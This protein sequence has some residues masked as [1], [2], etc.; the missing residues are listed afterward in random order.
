MDQPRYR[1]FGAQNT[2][3]DMQEKCPAEVIKVMP[4]RE[5][6]CDSRLRSFDEVWEMDLN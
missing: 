2:S 6:S 5:K 1:K 4:S 3:D